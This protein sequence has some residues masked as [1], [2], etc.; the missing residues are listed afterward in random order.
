MVTTAT[1][2]SSSSTA[3]TPSPP[4]QGPNTSSSESFPARR[5]NADLSRHDGHLLQS[6]QWGEFKKLHG[7]DAER[8]RVEQP[9]GSA[10]AQVLFRH[11]GPVSIGYIPRGPTLAGD[12]PTLFKVLMAEI[13]AVCRDRR[14]VSLLVEP[15]TRL[16]LSGTYKSA[17]F[18][19]GQEAF[20]PMRTVKV[21][22]LDDQALL[23]QMH[24][25]TRYNVRLAQRRGVVVQ[26]R[27]GDADAID[28][29]YALLADTAQ[30]N[31]FGIHERSYYADFMRIFGEQALLL[32]AVIDG[33]VAAGLIAARF[34]DEAIY[35]YGGSST[36][37][38]A[39]GAAFLL[40]FEAM[41]WARDQGCRRYDLWGI[42]LQDPGSSDDTRR[43]AGTH[44][45]DWRGLYNFKVR[46]GG[47][48]ISYPPAM[49]RRY[50]PILSWIGRHATVLRG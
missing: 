6:W 19:R 36:E 16:G 37:F 4:H 33:T 17:G 13:D 47:Q 25:K 20:Q 11:R 46:F 28:T 44:G 49:E 1:K 9:A 5:W 35:M 41:R 2:S 21:P 42:P 30:R 38:R 18:V 23:D 32:F 26:R 22:L 7:W 40:Q 14:A 48:V 10:L 31:E 43:M 15:D 50:H 3:P 27:D 39:H 29:F 24:Q 8:V 34:A 45:D 12:R